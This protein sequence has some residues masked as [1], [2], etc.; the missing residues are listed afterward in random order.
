MLRY[1]QAI[2]R[3]SLMS[4]VL[5]FVSSC[6]KYYEIIPAE[7][8]QGTEKKRPVQIVS[9]FIKTLAL[10]DEFSTQAIF[11]VLWLSDTV[12]AEYARAYA[13]RRGKD[14]H[15]RDVMLRRQMEENN[16]WISFYLLADVRQKTNINLNE[17]QSR[18][19]VY[20]RFAHNKTIE[21]VSIKEVELESEIQHFFGHR[22]NQFKTVYLIKFPAKSLDG[23]PY[24]VTKDSFKFV[25]AS[26]DREGVVSWSLPQ[27]ADNKEYDEDYYWC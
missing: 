12:R 23:K 15:M 3:M 10:Y 8:P 20:L 18:W 2:L 26:P 17:K 24:P 5:V 25:V 7:F 9:P 14:T 6:V 4:Y 27:T 1:I 22:F 11:D 13:S 21:P 16:H 19:S